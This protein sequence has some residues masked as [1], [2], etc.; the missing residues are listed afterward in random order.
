MIVKNIEYSRNFCKDLKKIP[1]DIKEKLIKTEKIFKENPVHPSLRLHRL[2]EKLKEFWS[3]S[4]NMDYRIIFRRIDDGTIVFF[5]I[6][7]H[8]IYEK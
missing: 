2:H 7:K 5:S 6:G 3:I 8:D 1:Q 4:I